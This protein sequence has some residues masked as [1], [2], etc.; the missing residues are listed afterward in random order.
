MKKNLPY[1]KLQVIFCFN[2]LIS[3]KKQSCEDPNVEPFDSMLLYLAIDTGI[4]LFNTHNIIII[5]PNMG[6]YFIVSF[7]SHKEFSVLA[8]SGH[9]NQIHNTVHNWVCFVTYKN[10]CKQTRNQIKNRHHHHHS[11]ALFTRVTS[12]I[13][14]NN[15]ERG[16]AEVIYRG[17][18]YPYGYAKAN[19]WSL[20]LWITNRYVWFCTL[21]HCEVLSVQFTP[22]L[23]IQGSLLLT[24]MSKRTHVSVTEKWGIRKDDEKMKEHSSIRTWAS[25]GY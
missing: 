24:V 2:G 25:F 18:S 11:S 16:T 14:N 10:A 19:R 17:V 5:L 15:F 12:C 6:N 21:S 23:Q 3:Q 1:L 4:R 20:S 9:R 13:P 7:L 8:F 22:L